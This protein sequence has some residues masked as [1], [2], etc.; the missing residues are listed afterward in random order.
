MPQT[1]MR[2][3]MAEDEHHRVDEYAIGFFDIVCIRIVVFLRIGKV[4]IPLGKA[5]DQL[6]SVMEKLVCITGCLSVNLMTH[7]VKTVNQRLVGQFLEE[8]DMAITHDPEEREKRL[9]DRDL[10]FN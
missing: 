3:F 5:M 4:L 7:F 10:L 9:M 2:Y 6:H 8:N 1:H